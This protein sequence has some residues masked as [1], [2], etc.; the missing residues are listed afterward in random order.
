MEEPRCDRPNTIQTQKT[1]SSHIAEDGQYIQGVVGNS[2]AR[3]ANTAELYRAHPS[4]FQRIETNEAAHIWSDKRLLS[5]KEKLTDGFVARFSKELIVIDKRQDVRLREFL[6]FCR[7]VMLGKRTCQEKVAAISEAVSSAL[8]GAGSDEASANSG[9]SL[10]SRM[11]SLI[12]VSGKKPHENMPLGETFLGGHIFGLGD[13]YGGAGI[14][15]HRAMLF[16][17]ACDELGVCHCAMV[18]GIMPPQFCKESDDGLVRFRKDSN[19]GNIDHMWNIVHV[20]GSNFVV[21]A[22]NFPGQ[23]I[24][25]KGLADLPVKFARIRGHTGMSLFK[26]KTFDGLAREPSDSDVESEADLECT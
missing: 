7:G 11:Q 17:Y 14:C 4:V 23:L 10:I 5:F 19:I 1:R 8:G 15:R 9:A 26:K 21:D 13:A 22:L 20:D 6:A 24:S 2:A 18:D 25:S 16:K 3:S 12:E